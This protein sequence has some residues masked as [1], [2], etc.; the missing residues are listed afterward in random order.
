[1]PD[2][3]GKICCVLWDSCNPLTQQTSELS[4]HEPIFL[5]TEDKKTYIDC[6]QAVRASIRAYEELHA[7]YNVNRGAK[8]TIDPKAALAFLHDRSTTR[9]MEQTE[10]K[11]FQT[12]ASSVTNS[13]ELEV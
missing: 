6:V 9:Q 4:V 1:M 2:S 3:K 11:T 8:L 7:V 5:M 12:S 10:K 13:G